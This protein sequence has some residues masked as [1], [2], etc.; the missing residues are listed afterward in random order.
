MLE[1]TFLSTLQERHN[2][3]N[4][5]IK[6]ISNILRMGLL[7]FM[8][9]LQIYQINLN[10]FLKCCTNLYSQYQSMIVLS[11]H[12]YMILTDCK[13][14]LINLVSMK[15]YH[16]VDLIY[17]ILISKEIEAIFSFSLFFLSVKCSFVVFVHFYIWD[18]SLFIEFKFPLYILNAST[19]SVIVVASTFSHSSLLFDDV[20]FLKYNIVEN[21]NIF[22]PFL[23]F[24]C[25]V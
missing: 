4:T 24:L 14:N 7:S 9:Y 1:K 19:L 23:C 18:L 21:I 22:L 6:Y 2:I 16:L 8:V 3:R 10:L 12:I 25:L 13:N 5:M 11:H 15:L 20:Q 17:M